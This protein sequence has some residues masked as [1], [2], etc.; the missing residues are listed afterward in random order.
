MPWIRALAQFPTPASATLIVPIYEQ[1]LNCI[2]GS[3]YYKP[4]KLATL[5]SH[6]RVSEFLL[7]IGQLR[8]R[9]REPV[10]ASL[11]A[12]R[13]APAEQ[14]RLDSLYLRQVRVALFGQAGQAPGTPSLQLDREQDH[15]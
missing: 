14:P 5:L 15:E 4:R 10:P 3:S 9:L 2:H 13:L 6:Y 7:G 12:I 1:S 8:Q 11:N